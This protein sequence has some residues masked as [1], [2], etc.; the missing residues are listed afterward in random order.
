M[1]KLL[2]FLF[3]ASLLASCATQKGYDYNTHHRKSRNA[4]PSK[5]YQKHKF[6]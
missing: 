1:K 2:L 5:C 4:K 6:N 3:C